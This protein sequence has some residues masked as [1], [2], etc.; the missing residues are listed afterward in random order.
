[1]AS[2]LAPGVYV[3]EVPGGSRPISAVG[4][5]TAVFFGVA[6]GTDAPE[7]VATP[8]TSYSEFL[9]VF[10]TD[11]EASTP[12]TAAAAG[13]FQ[14]GGGRLYIV[15]LGDKAKQISPDDI[16]LIEALDSISI[17]A[18]PGFTDA[19]S[20]EALIG[21]C[22]ARRDW[23]AVLDCPAEIDAIDDLTRSV[24][25]GGLRPR[26]SD[27]G[28]AAVYAPWIVIV[29]PITRARTPAPPSGHVCGLYAATDAR[30]GVHKAP[31]NAPLVGALNVTRA[32]SQREQ[33]VLNPVG[34]NCIRLFDDGIRV[35]GART[36]ADPTSEW[37]YVPV[38]RLV[39]MIA[40]SIERGTGW[41]VFEPNDLTLWKSLR[42]DIGAFLDG[43]WRTGALAGAKPA[44]AYFVKCNSETTTQAD[45]DEGR[46][47]ALIGIAPVKPAEFVIIR[48]GQ[49]LGQSMVEEG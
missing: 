49:S 17:I 36:L 22:E 8:V 5:S 35:W 32:I 37:R 30:R 21:A 48:I 14:N 27:R 26:S 28:V 4:T 20:Y 2:Y 41:V 24:Q 16:A 44:E 6:P 12:L 42:R 23:F 3:E 46:V 29:D 7:R 10:A 39:T 15:H 25:A 1:M 19:E 11:A 18:A 34:V 13:F 31:A 40:Q 45:I 33:E 47:I 9:R 38:R 43:L